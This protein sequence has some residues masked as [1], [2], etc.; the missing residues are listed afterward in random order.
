MVLCDQFFPFN[1]SIN[2]FTDV[3]I[4]IPFDFI[5]MSHMMCHAYGYVIGNVSVKPFEEVTRLF[6]VDMLQYII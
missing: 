4:E 1:H 5:A 2:T 6:V 3:G